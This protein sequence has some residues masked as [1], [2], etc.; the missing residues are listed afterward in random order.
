M[1]R[2]LLD[3]FKSFIDRTKSLELFCLEGFAPSQS[4]RNRNPQDNAR[5]RKSFPILVSVTLF[6]VPPK[7]EP[8]LYHVNS[9]L[10]LTIGLESF[11]GFGYMNEAAF[12]KDDW[13]DFALRLKMNVDI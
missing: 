9:A 10:V 1:R 11:D 8:P 7:L 12:S 3:K 2:G 6:R 4:E 13:F 5:Q